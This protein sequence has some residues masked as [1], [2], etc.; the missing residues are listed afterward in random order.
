MEIYND[1]I[2]VKSE[3]ATE[4]L[5]HLRRGFEKMM[6]SLI[7]TQSTK[8][9]FWSSSRKFSRVSGSPKRSRSQS[10]QSQGHHYGQGS[11]K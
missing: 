1:D 8:I 6:I 2:V 7:E 9:C 10:K 3:K 11:A 5:K 4:H